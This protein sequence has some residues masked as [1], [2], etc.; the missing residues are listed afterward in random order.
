MTGTTSGR[1]P[2]CFTPQKAQF[3]SFRVKGSGQS[4][5]GLEPELIASRRLATRPRTIIP[6]N[7]CIV[8]GKAIAA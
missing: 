1:P 8:G 4:L 7:Y 2:S 3:P 6:T 5:I